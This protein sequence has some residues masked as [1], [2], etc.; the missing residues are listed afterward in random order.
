MRGD[1]TDKLSGMEQVRRSDDGELCGCVALF[2]GRWRAM[3]LFGARLGEHGTRDEAVAQVL[4]EGLASLAERWTLRYPDGATDIV[5]V[6]E[7]HPGSVTLAVGY[8]SMLGAP[9][10]TITADQLASGDWELSR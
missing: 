10:L 2:D 5:C 1:P 8:Y 7:A 9:T 6:Q 4:T 3:T